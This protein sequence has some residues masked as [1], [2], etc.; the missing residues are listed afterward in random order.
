MGI[1]RRLKSDFNK[2]VGRFKDQI[3]EAF[4]DQDKALAKLVEHLEE[5]QNENEELRERNKQLQNNMVTLQETQTGICFVM[6]QL[7]AKVDDLIAEKEAYI[8][9]ESPQVIAARQELDD[10][11]LKTAE[12]QKLKLGMAEL[13]V[14]CKQLEEAKDSLE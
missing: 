1:E 13:E 3:Q 5:V 2:R 9:A 12:N 10:N 7:E 14:A 11:E 6:K 8:V 4:S